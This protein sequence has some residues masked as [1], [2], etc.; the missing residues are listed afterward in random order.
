MNSPIKFVLMLP[1]FTMCLLFATACPGPDWPKC[2]N[3]DHCESKGDSAMNYVCVFGKCQE[4]GRDTDCKGPKKCRKNRCIELCKDDASCG[5][6]MTC[7]STGECE[8]RTGPAPGSVEQ[9]GQCN[10]TV[11]CKDGLTCFDNTC[12]TDEE[13]ERLRLE[14]EA[15]SQN[16]ADGNGGETD[17]DSSDAANCEDEARIDFEFNMF[18]LTESAQATLD[19]YSKCLSANEGFS[20]TI[21]GHADERGTTQYNLDLGQRR[22]ES[23]KAYLKRLGVAGGRIRAVSY[24][25]E[26][27]VDEGS[28]ESAW[29]QNR[30][31]E[32]R[33]KR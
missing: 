17:A 15:A 11:D 16:G 9:G 33:L 25:E 28:N 23:A 27:P 13:A 30:R 1:I 10:D 20:L 31:G 18:E 22:A 6:G 29:S 21:E 8:K 32:L 14:Q 2:E 12:M 5:P 4:C 19:D 24:G 7:T 26:R 3:D